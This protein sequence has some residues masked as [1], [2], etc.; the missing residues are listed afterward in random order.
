MTTPTTLDPVTLDP[1]NP[2]V[3][4]GAPTI[5]GVNSDF[6]SGKCE[7]DYIRSLAAAESAAQDAADEIAHDVVSP[8]E[9]GATEDEATVVFKRLYAASE[10]ALAVLRQD[11]TAVDAATEA[12]PKAVG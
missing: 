11:P 5:R 1:E 3:L 12:A 4:C 7:D 2:C 10:A 8:P 9:D 6:C